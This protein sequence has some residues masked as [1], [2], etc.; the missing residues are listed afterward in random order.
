MIHN[1]H[2]HYHHRRHVAVMGLGHLMTRS[3]LTYPEDFS[4]ASPDS[5]YLWVCGVN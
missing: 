3:D 1:H 5:Y 4:M 2:H